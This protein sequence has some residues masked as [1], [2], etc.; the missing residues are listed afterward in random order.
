M[1]LVFWGGALAVGFVS[2]A[3]A[4]AATQAT[5]LFHLLLFNPWFALVAHA[6]RIRAVGLGGGSASFPA[7]RARAFPRPSPRGT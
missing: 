7:R 3:F 2:V 4:A 6:S 1:R 5:R